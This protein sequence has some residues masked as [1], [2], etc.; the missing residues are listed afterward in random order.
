MSTNSYHVLY[1]THYASVT[2]GVDHIRG[3]GSIQVAESLNKNLSPNQIQKGQKVY[4]YDN[5]F[6]MNILMDDF[7]RMDLFFKKFATDKPMHSVQCFSDQSKSYYNTQ[8]IKTKTLTLT[9]VDKEKNRL[10]DQKTG[11]P[12]IIIFA[13]MTFLNGNSKYI[14]YKCSFEDCMILR[15]WVYYCSTI[16]PGLGAM[17]DDL[18]KYITKRNVSD[19]KKELQQQDNQYN[20]QGFQG[21]K[22]SFGGQP[23]QGGQGFGTQGFGGQQTP[24]LGGQQGFGNQT[25]QGGSQGFGGQPPQGGF[26]NGTP[27]KPDVVDNKKQPPENPGTDDTYLF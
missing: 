20:N 17:F 1:N 2:L 18:V 4:D 3:I 21:N 19:I 11:L 5:A 13:N 12:Y 27:E 9:C 8:G 6:Y 10:V 16:M 23:P 7:C 24:P 26:Q 15:N 14:Q 22:Q 25:P